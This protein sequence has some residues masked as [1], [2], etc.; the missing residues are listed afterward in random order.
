MFSRRIYTSV[1]FLFSS[2]LVIAQVDK[3]NYALL[4]EISGKDL[5]QKS[6][7]FGSMHVHDERAFEFSDSVLITAQQAE[8]FAMEVHPDE[9]MDFMMQMF[10]MEDTVNVLKEMLSPE[11]YDRLNEI[12]IKKEGKPIDSLVNKNP[13]IIELMLSDFDEPENTKKRK[14]PVDLFFY[15][16]FKVQE[17]SVF[18]LEKMKDYQNLTRSFFQM[19]EKNNYPDDHEPTEEETRAQFEELLDLYRRGDLGEVEKYIK[20]FAVDEAYDYEMLGARNIKMV[21]AYLE[22]ARKQS[23]FGVVGTAHLPGKDGMLELLRKQGYQVRKIEATF[24][25][26]AEKFEM[27]KNTLSWH[28]TE[29]TQ[30][31]YIVKTP[32]TFEKLTAFDIPEFDMDMRMSMDFLEMDMYMTMNMNY[33]LEAPQ[34]VDQADFFEEILKGWNDGEGLEVLE[35]RPIESTGIAGYRFHT[36][37]EE[38]YQWWQIYFRENEKLVNMFCVWREQPSEEIDNI[39]QFFSSILLPPLTVPGIQ[40]FENSE[41]AFS[42]QLPAEPSLTWLSKKEITEGAEGIA[43]RLLRVHM[44]QSV[45]RD[46]TSRFL[47]R[48]HDLGAGKLSFDADVDLERQMLALSFRWGEPKKDLEYFQ[49]QGHPAVKTVYEVEKTNLHCVAVLR[50]NRIYLLVGQ[51]FDEKKQQ[52]EL[53]AFFDSFTFLPYQY[54]E[55]KPTKIP[56]FEMELGFPNELTIDTSKITKENYPS[57]SEFDYFS[58]DTLSGLSYALMLYNWDPYYESD[59]P[60]IFYEQVGETLCEDESYEHCKSI[61]FQG[62]PAWEM[63]KVEPGSKVRSHRLIFYRNQHFVE[64]AVIGLENEE[65]DIPWRFFKSFKYLKDF[66]GEFYKKDRTDDL[67]KDLQSTNDARRVQAEKGLDNH[68]FTKEDLPKI[69]S[70]LEKDFPFDTIHSTSIHNHLLYEL[71]YYVKD[72]TTVPFLKRLFE[73]KSGNTALQNRILMCLTR[74]KTKESFKAFFE[75]ANDYRK[76]QYDEYVYNDIFSPLRDTLEL[77]AEFYP[78]LLQ[79]QENEALEYDAYRVIFNLLSKDLLAKDLANQNRDFIYQK[80][81]GFAEQYQM[82]SQTDSIPYIEKFWHLDALLIILGELEPSE[83]VDQL[84]SKLQDFQNRKLQVTIVDALLMHQQ[85]INRSVFENISLE[86]YYWFELTNNLD[87]E[88][89]L[90]AIPK[91]LLTQEMAVSARVHSDIE[92]RLDLISYFEIIDIKPYKYGDEKLNLYRYKFSVKGYDGTYLGVC[93]QPKDKERYEVFPKVYDYSAE[94]LTE[95]NMEDLYK[96][97][98]NDLEN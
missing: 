12:V 13:F 90:K 43:E 35:K 24:T 53:D 62:E 39:E 58:S 95:N 15:K 81:K 31:G 59:N 29:S 18:G 40:I 20:S 25:G 69:Y 86:P 57:L 14:Q 16:L 9:M 3:S 17:K 38:G 45:K 54:Q 44:F 77:A 52:Q 11:A 22:L 98:I 60:G 10:T 4:W 48:Y 2:F 73:K 51:V 27:P 94:H 91:D 26:W 41:G 84:L 23:L 67:L 5:P 56:D 28:T 42:V 68:N 75:L 96:E 8:A 7:L 82:F 74:Q 49:F 33:F 89:N 92:D 46:Q 50:H 47:I 19:F 87:Y 76:N 65:E 85:K 78:Q 61:T 34:K 66:D 63:I 97:I 72:E 36:K 79:L 70:I 71:E 88:N 83:E 37:N 93:S 80:V 32:E 30:F 1:L 55:L 6:W 21:K 64:L